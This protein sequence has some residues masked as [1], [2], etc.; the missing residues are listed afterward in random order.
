[1]HLSV[2]VTP[3]SKKNE[4]IGWQQDVLKIRLTA[5]PLEGR[6]NEALRQFL[7]QRLHLPPTSLTLLRGNHGR[8]KLIDVPLECTD[9]KKLLE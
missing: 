5:P 7:A 3:N 8:N 4:I 2:R 1:M 6:A 9:I